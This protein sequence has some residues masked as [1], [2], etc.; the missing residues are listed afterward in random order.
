MCL[1]LVIILYSIIFNILIPMIGLILVLPGQ[2]ENKKPL[3]FLRTIYMTYILG[4]TRPSLI[5]TQ[6]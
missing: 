5:E 4:L 6:S 1:A 3:I 2:G